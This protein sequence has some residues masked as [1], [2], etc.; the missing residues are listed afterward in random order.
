LKVSN[1]ARIRA[2]ADGN[3]SEKGELKVPNDSE[4]SSFIKQVL[5]SA[6]VAIPKPG[7]RLSLHE[8]DRAL[9]LAGLDVSKR[10]SIK[11]TLYHRGNLAR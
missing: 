5:A 9:S 3:Q 11:A 7:E 8:V 2:V 4:L 1:L 10:M 6:S